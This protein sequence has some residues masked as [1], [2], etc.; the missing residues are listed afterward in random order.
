MFFLLFTDMLLSPPQTVRSIHL[1]VTTSPTVSTDCSFKTDILTATTNQTKVIIN[2]LFNYLNYSSY[3]PFSLLF[4]LSLIL[5]FWGNAGSSAHRRRY[6][7]SVVIIYYYNLV[8][9]ITK[10]FKS[11]STVAYIINK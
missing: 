8:L 9:C 3:Y 2:Y 10:Y 11:N 4:H 1:Y 6:I 5:N 7:S